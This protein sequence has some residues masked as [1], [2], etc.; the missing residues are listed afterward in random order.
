MEAESLESPNATRRSILSW[1]GALSLSPDVPLPS[2]VPVIQR[3]V[4]STK[5]CGQ[6]NRDS[7]SPPPKSSLKMPGRG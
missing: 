2:P 6:D 4:A 7:D 5:I 3:H 1:H